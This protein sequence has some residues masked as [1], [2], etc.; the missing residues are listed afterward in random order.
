[1]IFHTAIEEIIVHTDQMIKSP[2]SCACFTGREVCMTQLT[3]GSATFRS[4]NCQIHLT[5][6][7]RW[8]SS[9]VWLFAAAMTRLP[10]Y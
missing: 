10:L 6:V 8:R 7:R 3:M 4:G 5:D 2:L 1:M 9:V